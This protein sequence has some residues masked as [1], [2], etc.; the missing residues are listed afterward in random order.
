MGEK[1]LRITVMLCLV[2]LIVTACINIIV[3]TIIKEQINFGFWI[4]GFIVDITLL[5]LVGYLMYIFQIHILSNYK[6]F[7]RRL[8]SFVLGNQK[9]IN[10]KH[11]KGLFAK[12]HK[13]LDMLEDNFMEL[14][15]FAKKIGEGDFEMELSKN[16]LRFSLAKSLLDMKNRLQ[17][18]QKEEEQR[19]WS[20]RGIAE[21]SH[22]LR[23]NTNFDLSKVTNLFI[24]YLCKYIKAQQGAIFILNDNNPKKAFLE[25]LSSY[26]YNS[27]Q[28]QQKHRS[29]ED[30]F[31]GECV[32]RKKLIK[33]FDIPET[34]TKIT[35]ALGQTLPKNIII[36]PISFKD[37]VY[38]VLELSTL[39]VLE[40]FEVE[41]LETIARNLA[42]T[43]ETSK[44]NAQTKKLL[45][46]TTLIK[47]ELM[48]R[49]QIMMENIELLDELQNTVEI[50]RQTIEQQALVIA[51]LSK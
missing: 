43:F 30:G 8:Y 44:T 9:E 42:V 46:E 12:A 38:G 18:L 35:S 45:E 20:I 16:T 50:Q 47:D 26:A 6:H 23:T 39:E 21:F 41:F 5:G 27:T 48:T 25:L 31:L 24:S 17:T 33:I 4:W 34:Y 49:E 40:D 3:A 28:F 11:K 32:R 2:L 51:S 37:V 19:N 7:L 15:I 13:D 1:R 10:A 14:E 29:L 22:I 36:V